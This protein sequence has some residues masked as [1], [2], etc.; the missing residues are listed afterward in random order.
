VNRVTI[1][2]LSALVAILSLCGMAAQQ[3]GCDLP[4]VV[5]STKADAATY[6][7]E[8]SQ[9]AIPSAV[10]SGL[11]KLNRERKIVATLFEA[12]TKDGSGDTPEQ[13][14]APL[15]AATTAGLP[16]LVATAGATVLNVAKPTT[17]AETLE[18]V[19]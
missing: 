3:K 4:N 14:K 19:P 11:N 9:H 13:Y 1:Q 12:D 10:L 5:P 18:A 2:R 15:A 17:E 6:V 16:A 8:K 7:Y